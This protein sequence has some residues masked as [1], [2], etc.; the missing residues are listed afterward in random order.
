MSTLIIYHTP[1]RA[2]PFSTPP[3]IV[4]HHKADKEGRK[5]GTDIRTNGDERERDRS[6]VS[7]SVGPDSQTVGRGQDLSGEEDD[8]RWFSGKAASYTLV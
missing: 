5:E 4:R 7:Q 3:L 6:S 8:E 2:S 1:C